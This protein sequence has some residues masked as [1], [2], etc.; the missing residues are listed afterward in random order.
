MESGRMLTDVLLVY[1]VRKLY[2]VC[3][4]YTSTDNLYSTPIIKILLINPLVDFLGVPPTHSFE[5]TS[6]ANQHCF[7]TALC[8][9]LVKGKM[10]Y[11]YPFIQ[12]CVPIYKKRLMELSRFKNLSTKCRIF[13][14]CKLCGATLPCTMC[15]QCSEDAGWKWEGLTVIPFIF[16]W[17][18][19]KV[20]NWKTTL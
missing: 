18:G 20:Y 2:A 5:I 13:F 4:W 12:I 3:V 1:V 6:L 10:G 7:N 8:H 19:A 9:Q 11:S 17:F 15:A 16:Y 14:E